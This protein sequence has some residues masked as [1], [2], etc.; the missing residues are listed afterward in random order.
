LSLVS[1]T[2]L[3]ISNLAVVIAHHKTIMEI[4]S[5]TYRPRRHSEEKPTGCW[6]SLTEHA[7]CKYL[8][9]TTI[10]FLSLVLL[11]IPVLFYFIH[12][13]LEDVDKQ[14][15]DEEN[16]EKNVKR[17]VGKIADKEKL[18]KEIENKRKEIYAKIQ[19]LKSLKKDR[20]FIIP[21]KLGFFALAG[22]I[23]SVFTLAVWFI[24]NQTQIHVY[25]HQN[26]VLYG[27]CISLLIGSVVGLYEI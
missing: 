3:Y 22:F 9:L 4:V 26:Y 21:Y 15:K 5:F 27:S 23:P 6:H 18:D 17:L 10:I 19:E 12:K 16:N 2:L 1:V 11:D 25:P 20:S 24:D 13:Q 14:I 7:C 8:K